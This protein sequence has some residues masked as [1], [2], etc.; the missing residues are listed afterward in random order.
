MQIF[1]GANFHEFRKNYFCEIL[2][3]LSDQWD[4]NGH[5]RK[6]FSRNFAFR[7]ICKKFAPRTFHTIRYYGGSYYINNI[8][9]ASVG[10]VP[11][12]YGSRHVCVL[13]IPRDSSSCISTIA[14]T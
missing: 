9:Y 10:G 3:C 12:A 14:E 5:L 7:P 6:I 13:V 11:E 8:H 1:H 2:R 4:S